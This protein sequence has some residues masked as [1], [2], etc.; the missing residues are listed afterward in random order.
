MNRSVLMMAMV[1]S[2]G[3]AC[4]AST[5]LATISS[6]QPFNIDGHPVSVPGVS[7]WPLV[8]GDEVTTSTAPGTI[9]FQDGSTIKLGAKSAAR[10][11]GTNAHPK[12]VLMAG[13]LDYKLS[14]GSKLELG[15][16]GMPDTDAPAATGAPANAGQV[17]AATAGGA[18]TAGTAGVST[19]AVVTGTLVAAG[20]VAVIPAHNAVATPAS[21]YLPPLSTP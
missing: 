18:G 1:T 4:L 5:P 6:P 14:P 19:A 15:S 8:I 9:L 21:S 17:P 12:L 11:A 7:S 13:N 2:L 20:M 16:P 10:L 3:F